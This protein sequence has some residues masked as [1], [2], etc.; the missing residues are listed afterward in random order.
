MIYLIIT[1]SINNKVGNNDQEHRRNRYIDCIK[2][3]LK[4]IRDD[5]MIKPIIVENNGQRN[6]Y[7]D[8]LGCDVLYT[9]NN[10]FYFSHKAVNELLDIKQ[11]I[12]HYNIDDDD[13]I[14]K[15]TG[16]YKILDKSFIDLIKSNIEK[17]DAFVKFF[18]VCTLKYLY[19]DCVLGLF[20][21]KSKYLKLFNY[22]HRPSAECEFAIFVRNFVK[23]K[24][25][26]IKTLNVECCFA[27]N[28]RI[29][30]V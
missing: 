18:N 22:S 11:V 17:Y 21:I 13:F 6:T 25:M 28:L 1:T 7:L 8:D 15:L 4:L 19:D 10:A 14:I 30:T 27:D 9:N 3:S 16:R 26:E 20:A 2:S 24:V 23:D 5:K 29:L 12:Q